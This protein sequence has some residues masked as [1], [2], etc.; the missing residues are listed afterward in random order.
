MDTGILPTRPAL[1]FCVWAS[2]TRKC[3]LPRCG[4][5]GCGASYAKSAASYAG[6]PQTVFSQKSRSSPT[7]TTTTVDI[8]GYPGA[9]L[10]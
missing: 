5:G 7:T 10:R 3:G 1:V 2:R 6:A 9:R 4:H 8:Y